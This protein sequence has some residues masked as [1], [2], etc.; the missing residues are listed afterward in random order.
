[1]RTL[2]HSCAF[3]VTVILLNF[4]LITAAS[5]ADNTPTRLFIPSINL[6][7]AV[8]PVGWKLVEING[9]TYGEWL[10]DDNL[11]GWHKLSA[12]VGEV[13]NTVLNGHS[14]VHGQVFRDLHQLQ[15]GSEIILF[16]GENARRYVVTER[17]EVQ[18]AN[19]SQE[20]RERNA[21]LIA[22]TD[23]ERLTLITCTQPGATHRL[24]VIAHP[25]E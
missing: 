4:T 25:V 1:M 15:L 23:D 24:L 8:I 13:G 9:Q 22:P 2:S 21:Q 16:A 14:N 5:A 18:E 19:V 10:V 17:I 11:V 3:I 20:E 6:D 12:K 7:S